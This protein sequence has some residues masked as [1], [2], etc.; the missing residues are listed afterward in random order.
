MRIDILFLSNKA[1]EKAGVLDIAVAA[2]CYQTAKCENIGIC[3][4]FWE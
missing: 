1:M 4:P 2:R 3:V